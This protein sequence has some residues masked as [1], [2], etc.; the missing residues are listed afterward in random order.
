[1]K[2]SILIFGFSLLILIGCGKEESKPAST[3]FAATIDGE[4]VQFQNPRVLIKRENGIPFSKEIKGEVISDETVQKALNFRF[5]GE[6]NS[7]NTDSS[8]IVIMGVY[9]EDDYSD[10]WSNTSGSGGIDITITNHTSQRASGTF[11]DFM[12]SNTNDTLF[13][14]DV[15]F[16]NIPIRYADI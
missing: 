2:A 14:T 13:V 1:M 8:F 16:H 15:S 5:A 7:A 9:Y 11:N 6:L 12:A 4:I 3:S 10:S